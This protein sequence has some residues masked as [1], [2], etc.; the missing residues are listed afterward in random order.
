MA[1]KPPKKRHE[2]R[3]INI[4]EGLFKTIKANSKKKRI[5]QG[6]EIINFLET[7]NYK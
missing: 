3:V 7:N 1:E 4:P 6:N 2:V 5:T